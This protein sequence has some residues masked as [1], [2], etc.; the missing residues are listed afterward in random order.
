MKWFF[1][2][3]MIFLAVWGD[4]LLGN[5]GLV[6]GLTGFALT[7][8]FLCGARIPAVAAAVAVGLMMDLLYCREW[9]GSGPLFLICLFAADWSCTEAESRQLLDA[10]FPGAVVGGVFAAGC[11]GLECLSAG[12][13]Q[14]GY[15]LFWRSLFGAA[16][17]ALIFPVMVMFFDFFAYA[18]ELG[19]FCDLGARDLSLHRISLK[20]Y[21]ESRKY[22]EDS[23]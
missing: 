20:S 7:Y 19:G 1:A 21:R 17:G 14:W 5:L 6:C 15:P 3:A 8:F 10:V 13:T 2:A 12:M 16:V 22:G 9:L 11:V 18:L 23:R 4:L